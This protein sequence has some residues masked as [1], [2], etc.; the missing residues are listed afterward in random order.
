M[1]LEATFWASVD[2]LRGSVIP[3]ISPDTTRTGHICCYLGANRY[4]IDLRSSDPFRLAAK[5]K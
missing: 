3:V 5:R 1:V 4:F 2:I